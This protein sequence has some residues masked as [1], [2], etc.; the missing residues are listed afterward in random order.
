MR[1][2]IRRKGSRRRSRSPWKGPPPN[3]IDKPENQNWNISSEYHTTCLDQTSR[4]P[5][6]HETP[7]FQEY[8]GTTQLEQRSRSPSLSSGYSVSNEQMRSTLV[9]RQ[10]ARRLPIIPNKP[11]LLQINSHSVEEI[12]FPTL[13][14]SPTIPQNRIHEIINFP[15]VSASPTRKIGSEWKSLPE[16]IDQTGVNNQALP[17]TMSA[18]HQQNNTRNMARVS[19]S[20]SLKGIRELPQ[21][22]TEN[23][24]TF[25]SAS[26]ETELPPSYESIASASNRIQAPS[27]PILSQNFK[28]AKINFQKKE[29]HQSSQNNIKDLEPKNHLKEKSD[30]EEENDDDND[31]DD[32]DDWC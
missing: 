18:H 3:L 5:S 7:T 28:K 19:S 32:D 11:S 17:S 24:R 9:N 23:I 31:D 8:Y 4:T 10:G 16:E 29:N 25:Y 14:H 27:S 12:N 1:S 21:P 2:P 30:N 22:P 15:R 20:C 13:S 26:K 6:P